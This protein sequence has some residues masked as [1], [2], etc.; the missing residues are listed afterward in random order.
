MSIQRIILSALVIGA[1]AGVGCN[2]DRLPTYPTTGTIQFQDGRPVRFGSIEFYN[3]END[4]TARGTIGR[5]GTYQVGTFQPKDGTI[6][7]EHQVVIIQV[8]MPAPV[9]KSEDGAHHAVPHAHGRRAGDS[10]SKLQVESLCEPARGGCRIALIGSA[11]S[12]GVIAFKQGIAVT[13][14]ERLHH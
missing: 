7:G 5:D 10:R 8:L 3:V 2:S 4:I 12:K 13:P 6:A 14:G 11:G 9:I 1:L